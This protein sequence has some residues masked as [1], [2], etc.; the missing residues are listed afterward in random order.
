M[1]YDSVVNVS[2]SMQAASVSQ[3]GFGVPLL[4][5]YHTKFPE[6]VR[7]Y[8]TLA[9]MVTDGFATTDPAYL[10]ATALLAQSPSVERF[11]VGRRANPPAQ[12]V[13]CKPAAQNAVAYTV[14]INATSFTFTSDASATVA[15]IVAGLVA[16]INAGSEPVT[17]TA[18]GGT[19]FDLDA[20]VA[21]TLFRLELSSDYDGADVWTREDLTADPGVVADL[22][23]CALEQP[24]FY[25]VVLDSQSKA[26]IVAAAAWI[27]S[28]KLELC[29]SSA[30]TDCI[31]TASDDVMSALEAAGYTRTPGLYHPK[32]HQYAGA[33]WLGRVMP[34]DPGS[35]TWKFRA[36]TGVDAVA[37]T[38][39]QIANIV[40]KHGNYYA[41]VGGVSF[42]QEGWGPS[43][44]FMDLTNG[45]DWLSARIKEGTLALLVNADKIPYTDAGGAK[46]EN[47]LRQKL[48]DA[49]DKAFLADFWITAPLASAQSTA[50][51]TDRYWP[52]WQFG[53]TFAGAVHKVG[54]TGELTP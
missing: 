49:A 33:A 16:L 11:A 43:G 47:V 37:L 9:A 1:G 50:D 3:A 19:D 5:A 44:L 4:L 53:G 31:T 22:T 13:N 25:G 41:T 30:D 28:S 6:R 35:L 23:A 14:K 51:K 42:T 29:Y 12:S 18:N 54:F 15:E 32:P 21:G 7:Y 17:A 40:A 26:E 46:I 48:Q 38:D 45:V 39:T 24:D 34:N 20:D 2:I 52:G 36:L 27:E 8:T 10:M